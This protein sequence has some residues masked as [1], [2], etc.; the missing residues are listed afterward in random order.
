MTSTTITLPIVV[1]KKI[2][3]EIKHQRDRICYSLTCKELFNYF[4]TIT[5]VKEL[6]ISYSFQSLTEIIS[7]QSNLYQKRKFKIEI[8]SGQLQQQQIALEFQ[9]YDRVSQLLVRI[10]EHRDYVL[11]FDLVKKFIN[12]EE[13]ELWFYTRDDLQFQI[14]AGSIPNTVRILRLI[15]IGDYKIEGILEEGSI[16][17]SLLN[18]KVDYRL[19]KRDTELLLPRSL[20]ELELENMDGPINRVPSSLEKLTIH[21]VKENFR[22]TP[23]ILP[24]IKEMFFLMLF[25]GHP[26]VPG[27]IPNGVHKI[28]YCIKSPLHQNVLPE[29]L[30]ELEFG[31]S[32]EGDI[33]PNV[34]PKGVKKLTLPTHVGNIDQNGVLPPQVQELIMSAFITKETVL[35]KTLTRLV[36][37]FYH[38]QMQS[39]AYLDQLKSIVVALDEIKTGILPHGLEILTLTGNQVLDIEFD[40]I[41]SS[42][43]KMI[44]YFPVKIPLT[45]RK[46]PE[47]LK[48]LDLSQGI[49]ETIF[50]Y[51]PNQVEWLSYRDNGI[52]IPIGALPQSLKHLIL[53]KRKNPE[54]KDRS[55]LKG[56]LPSGL[57]ILD[58]SE[59]KDPIFDLDSLYIPTSVTQIILPKIKKPLTIDSFT[60]FILHLFSNA[61]SPIH[62]KLMTGCISLL[63]L[64][65]NDP[66]LYYKYN[67]G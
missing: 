58:L 19:I 4:G 24:C 7:K 28:F 16:P 60:Q 39:F 47:S 50:P 25:Y 14:P 23:G 67:S 53:M 45:Q 63:S 36:L 42:V 48:R 21:S 34:I 12:L 43:D 5:K 46:L 41:P 44:F 22:F 17:D 52:P 10:R 30:D 2:G 27:V 15:V 6:R 3:L 11:F 26:L 9:Y 32:F 37:N 61:I 56:V 51:I 59:Y 29:S 40:S 55:L 66:Y 65:K 49:L 54:T 62:I 35:P 18:L 13:L 38:P 57:E 1:L 33:V 31:F 64:D 20:K 8:D